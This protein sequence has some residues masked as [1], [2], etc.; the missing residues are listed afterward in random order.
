MALSQCSALLCKVLYKNRFEECTTCPVAP[1]FCSSCRVSWLVNLVLNTSNL[2]SRFFQNLILKWQL[3]NPRSSDC[4]Q[5]HI[6][7]LVYWKGML[8]IGQSQSC[9]WINYWSPWFGQRP[10]VFGGP[11]LE[12]GMYYLRFENQR[13]ENNVNLLSLCD[14][15]KMIITT[16]IGHKNAAFFLLGKAA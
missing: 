13:F 10:P 8:L 2:W 11:S 4:G 5:D 6:N 14:V 1:G 12:N 3:W 15:T 7:I 16:P 9:L